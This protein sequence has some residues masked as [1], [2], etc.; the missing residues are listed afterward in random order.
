MIHREAW[1]QLVALDERMKRTDPE[2]YV[3]LQLRAGKSLRDSLH[4]LWTNLLE[5]L[6]PWDI[7]VDP[8]YPWVSLLRRIP[9]EVIGFD[10]LSF[11]SE[12]MWFH[13]RLNSTIDRENW[14]SSPYTEPDETEWDKETEEEWDEHVLDTV[15]TR[16]HD[17]NQLLAKWDKIE[18][19]IAPLK[20]EDPEELWDNFMVPLIHEHAGE[21]DRDDTIW[22]EFLESIQ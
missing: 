14:T 19:A 12:L 17:Y 13:R 1:F 2:R 9:R 22:A 4:H 16:V 3:Y 20:G 6:E 7:G 10:P 5:R 8:E 15:E 21:E 11:F 18:R